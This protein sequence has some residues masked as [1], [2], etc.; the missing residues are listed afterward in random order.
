L[1]LIHSAKVATFQDFIAGN[2]NGLTMLFYGRPGTGK[3]LT[4]ERCVFPILYARRIP[5]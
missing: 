3:T 1:I 2:G 4:A 5:I